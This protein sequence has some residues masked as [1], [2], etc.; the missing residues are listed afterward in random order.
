MQAER[1]A[2][3]F[4]HTGRAPPVRVRVMQ[5]LR[6]DERGERKGQAYG[7]FGKIKAFIKNE[8]TSKHI[9]SVIKASR[10]TSR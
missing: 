5:L 4:P 10:E 8:L 6:K 3:G 1:A 2:G 7:V 9:Y